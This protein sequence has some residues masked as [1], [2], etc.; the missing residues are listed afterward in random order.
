MKKYNYILRI[1]CAF[2]T[3]FL[4]SL[5]GVLAKST[6]IFYSCCEEI[7]WFSPEINSYFIFLPVSEQDRCRPLILTLFFLT[8][9]L[10]SYNHSKLKFKFV[11]WFSLSKNITNLLTS[12]IMDLYLINL[13]WYNGSFIN[14]SIRQET[15]AWMILDWTWLQWFPEKFCVFPHACNFTTEGF[16]IILFAKSLNFIRLLECFFILNEVYLLKVYMNQ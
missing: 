10:K 1:I 12:V 7:C 6:Y 4:S 3:Q 16:Q 15:G 14:W 2:N 9:L 8:L 13:V 11:H 5:K